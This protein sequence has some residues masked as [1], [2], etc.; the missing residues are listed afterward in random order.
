MQLTE[1]MKNHLLEGVIA[2]QNEHNPLLEGLDLNRL[3]QTLESDLTEDELISLMISVGVDP[4]DTI[5]AMCLTMIDRKAP[6]TTEQNQ[7]PVVPTP[8][9]IRSWRVERPDHGGPLR[10]IHEHHHWK[11][12]I[13]SDT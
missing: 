10:R 4:T 1:Q 11:N 13:R 5:R 6:A 9:P 7:D 2:A 3:H 12:R 8:P